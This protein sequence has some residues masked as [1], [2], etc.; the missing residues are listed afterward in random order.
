[1]IRARWVIFLVFLTAASH[2][3][4][5]TDDVY[6][7]IASDLVTQSVRL[8][9]EGDEA[10]ARSLLERAAR[11]HPVNPDA[12]WLLASLDL[13][14]QEKTPETIQHL[15]RALEKGDG[16]T[17]IDPS[18]VE[19]EYA[20]I[21]LR[22]GRFNEV[23]VLLGDRE[24]DIAQGLLVEAMITGFSGRD[25]VG[26][27]REYRRNSESFLSDW[28]YFSRQE[29]P[30][31]ELYNWIVTTSIPEESEDLGYFLR[32][33]LHAISLYQSPI[34][35][36]LITLYYDAG[37]TDPIPAVYLVDSLES[38]WMAYLPGEVNLGGDVLHALAGK[39]EK[40]ISDYA[41]LRAFSQSRIDWD[42]DRDGFYE[43]ALLLEDGSVVTWESDVDTD[44]RREVEIDRRNG[45]DLVM[46]G[47]E[48]TVDIHYDPYPYVG[49]ITRLWSGNSE[50]AVIREVRRVEVSQFEPFLLETNPELDEWL[51]FNPGR[52][53]IQRVERVISDFLTA[54]D[55]FL[56]F[57]SQHIGETE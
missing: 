5:A 37:G 46:Y 9:N 56:V 57:K 41:L 48:E 30:S 49:R 50:S 29:S 12:Q 42:I 40:E 3:I 10:R 36:E 6:S 32:V 24:D 39:E 45:V 16:L 1:M 38:E 47:E 18:T 7:E 28:L 13:D 26:I 33:V 53:P 31:I 27:L 35:N 23:R 44:G 17:V 43:Q 15:E 19:L 8:L 22:T 34:R 11:I 55:S 51:A 25:S 54:Y 21:L 14:D 20:R 52:E 2:P 4:A